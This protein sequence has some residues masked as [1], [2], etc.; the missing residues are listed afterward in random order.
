MNHIKKYYVKKLN[1]IFVLAFLLILSGCGDKKTV[2]EK[3][4]NGQGGAE[5]FVK[6]D[7][8]N[9]IADC[10][11]SDDL[12]R[13]EEI[14]SDYFLDNVDDYEKQIEKFYDLFPDDFTPESAYCY[15]SNMDDKGGNKHG[16]DNMD[17]AGRFSFTDANGTRYTVYFVWLKLVSDDPS[18]QGIH[19]IDVISEDSE[20]NKNII[21]HGK[22]DPPGIYI[23]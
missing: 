10:I 11:N 16:Y 6:E 3:V 7:L 2:A 9:E 17:F 1:F 13:M 14:L 12:D 23:Y 18:K 21:P 22:N 15:Y 4:K 20:K 19:S 8:T 5:M